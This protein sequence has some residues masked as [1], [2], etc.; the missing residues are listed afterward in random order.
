MRVSGDL[1][2]KGTRHSKPTTV[3]G[4]VGEF[5]QDYFSWDRIT[6]SLIAEFRGEDHPVEAEGLP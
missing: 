4:S 2:L 1:Q 3:I 5:L 6:D